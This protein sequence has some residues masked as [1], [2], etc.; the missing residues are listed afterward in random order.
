MLYTNNPTIKYPIHLFIIR[1]CKSLENHYCFY[2]P[3]CSY[4]SVH[5]NCNIPMFLWDEPGALMHVAS[6]TLT[7]D[8]LSYAI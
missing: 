1:I 5:I 3:W 7:S 8:D 2:L 4:Q 6:Y